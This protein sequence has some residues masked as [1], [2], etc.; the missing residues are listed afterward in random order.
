M[1]CR[2]AALYLVNCPHIFFNKVQEQLLNEKES[3][4]SYYINIFN[5]TCWGKP[6]I[7]AALSH[8]WNVPIR[9][10]TSTKYRIIKLF[11]KS[12]YPGIILIANGY[13]NPSSRCTHYAA[14]ELIIPKQEMVPGY[15]TPYNDLVPINLTNQQEAQKAAISLAQ[16]G[17]QDH[18]LTAYPDVVK[19]IKILK[20]EV[21]K[22]KTR[23]EELTL[24]RDRL[25]SELLTLGLE[26][27][28]AK[29]SKKKLLPMQPTHN[30]TPSYYWN[31]K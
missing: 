11:H 26:V 8:M 25:G 29:V 28:D 6:I 2:Q 15:L 12:D 20:A 24:M 13:Y 1:L 30:Q 4:Q 31:K 22:M 18:I 3:Y 9:I 23:L 17:M 5:G 19:G 27:T 7:A 10:V 16:K 21:Q 14:T